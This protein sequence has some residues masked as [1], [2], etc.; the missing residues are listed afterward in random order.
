MIAHYD[1]NTDFPRFLTVEE[2]A[3]LL[4]VSD[5]RVS[6]WIGECKLPVAARSEYAGFLL[7]RWTVETVGRKLAEAV[8]PAA[9]LL[10]PSSKDMHREVS[11]T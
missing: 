6:L 1:K 4:G 5:A 3:R 8:P 10:T 9:R 11:M 2:T 7:L